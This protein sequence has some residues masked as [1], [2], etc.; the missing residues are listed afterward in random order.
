MIKDDSIYV[1]GTVVGVMPGTAY[2]VE[3]SNGHVVL[4]HVSGQM[5]RNFV[6]IAIGDTVNLQMSPYDLE[7]GRIVPQAG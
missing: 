3:L 6:R 7:K 2:R 5:R 4:A 1:S